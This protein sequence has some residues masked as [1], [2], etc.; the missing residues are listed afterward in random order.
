MCKNYTKCMQKLYKTLNL[1]IFCIQRLYKSK[2]WMIINVQKMYIKFLHIYKKCTNNYIL[3]FPNF[4]SNNDATSVLFRNFV[5]FQDQS[6][7]TPK[8]HRWIYIIDLFSLNLTYLNFNIF[9]I[10][11]L[12]FFQNVFFFW[13][14]VY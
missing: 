4:Y 10:F 1:Y 7:H 12:H 6:F 5:K 14:I 8:I 9:Y 2:F 13:H 3:Y 11:Y